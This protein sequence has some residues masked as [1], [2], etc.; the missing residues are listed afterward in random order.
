M[1][2][3]SL[4]PH[5]DPFKDCC[6]RLGVR[7][8]VLVVDKFLLQGRPEAFHHGV[9]IAVAGT[10]YALHGH[11]ERICRNRR[12]QRVRH[13][14]P[15]NTSAPCVHHAREVQEAFVSWNVGDVAQPLLV[16]SVCGEVTLKK[17]GRR[18]MRVRTTALSMASLRSLRGAG[19]AWRTW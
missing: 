3:D 4:V 2:S 13:A 6:T 19:K 18:R 7:A 12:M 14:P 9:V 17:I 1:D 16:W 5:L 8:E 10:A 15:N 11:R